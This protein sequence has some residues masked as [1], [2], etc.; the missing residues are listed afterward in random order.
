[1]SALHWK[2]AGSKQWACE[3]DTRF[4][5]RA[6][7]MGDGRWTWKIFAAGNSA[8]MASGIVNSPGAAKHAM[9]NFLKK[10]DQI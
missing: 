9:E 5:L 3:V 6:D 8:A 10:K 2:K 1:M 4:S 7:L